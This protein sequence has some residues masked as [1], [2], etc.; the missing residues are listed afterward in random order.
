[1]SAAIGLF[2][3]LSEECI[4]PDRA[5]RRTRDQVLKKL[6]RMYA[7]YKSTELTDLSLLQQA[8]LGHLRACDESR[9]VLRHVIVD[10][11]QDTNHV[12]EALLFH[13]AGGHHNLCVVGD[14]DQALYRF[15]GSTVENL[16]EFEDRC[17][18]HL[19]MP[20]AR[21]DL[22][23]N[24]RSR[25]A[26]VKFYRDFIDQI[27]WKKSPGK[28][29][30]YRV[31]GKRIEP[32]NDDAGPAVVASTPTDPMTVCTEVAALVHQ[33]I[34]DG[35]VEDAN[36]VAFLYPSL[37][38]EQVQ[39]M[40]AALEHKGLKVYAPRAGQFLQ[41][42]EALDIFGLCLLLFGRPNSTIPGMAEFFEWVDTAHAHGKK[43]AR[44]DR[45]TDRRTR[46]PT[47]CG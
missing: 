44:S 28:K 7:A 30:A 26:I 43:L 8:A 10:E 11:Y 16:V 41:V 32:D 23:R 33:L 18:A 34:E 47:G 5:L 27:D 45:R 36:Q 6:L 21:I 24:Y 14:D 37:K 42:S 15:R 17:T 31:E 22:G 39:R 9:H 29:G 40:I 20:P 3:R 1:V 35:K 38:S 2:N 19:G 12:Q 13:L 46:W 25:R 4:E